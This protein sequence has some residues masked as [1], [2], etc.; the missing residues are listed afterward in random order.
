MSGRITIGPFAYVRFHGVQKYSG[1]YTE[2]V[3]DEWADWLAS[4]LAAGHDVFAYFNNDAGAQAPRDAE[5]LRAKIDQRV[6]R[7]PESGTA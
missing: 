5:R 7:H 1:S 6:P 4:R 3:L 2:A